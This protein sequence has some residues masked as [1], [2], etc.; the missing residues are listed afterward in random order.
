[1]IYT[2]DQGF[3]LGDHGWF[4]KRLM[5]DQSLQM[6]M[7]MR[8]PGEIRA[9][10]SSDAIITNVDFAATFLDLAGLDPS[11]ILPTSQ[12]RSFL[13]I[14]RGHTPADW[15]DVAYYRYWEHVDP[16]HHAPAHYGIRTVDHKL[17]CYYGAGLGVPGASDELFDPEWELYDLRDD[18]AEINNVAEDPAYAGIRA[19]LEDK[20]ARCQRHYRDEP[21]TGPGT[22]RPQWGPHDE[23]VFERVKDY[24]AEV[25]AT[26]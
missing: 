17:I 16:I 18:P 26:S 14:L 19:E 3:F 6:P 2:S 20:L 11:E 4:D 24:V 1:V 13:P 12:G 7:L 5:F 25:N 23:T 9:G 10:T 15:P 21:Y 8:L 22:P